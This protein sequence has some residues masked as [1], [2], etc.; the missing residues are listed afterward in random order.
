MAAPIN[1]RDRLLQ[2]AA[3]RL[4][5]VDL[6]SNVNIPGDGTI[7]GQPVVTVVNAA[8][9]GGG[10]SNFFS[11][12]TSDPVGGNPGDAHFNSAT[13]TM[14][15]NI[16][17]VWTA[18]GTLSANQIIT[19]TLAAARIAA[20]SITADKISV[21]TLDV[22]STNMGA[23]TSGTLNGTAI[24]NLI[25]AN[26]TLNAD[27]TLSGGSGAITA[28]D[29][30]N[31][32]GVKPDANATQN[33]FTTS[34]SNPT[35]GAVGDAHWNSSTS[36]MWFNTPA[37][38]SR[39]GTI[40]AGEITVGTLAAA[41][42]AANSIT[43]DKLNVANLAAIN[44]NLGTVNAGS[45]TGTADINITGSA[46]FRGA[47]SSADG[48]ACGVFNDTGTQSFGVI[49]YSLTGN[50]SA[51][52][53]FAQTSGGGNGVYG[54]ALGSTD[55]GVRAQRIGSGTALSVSGP[56]TITSTSQVLN[57][58][59]TR[60][61]TAT[62][63]DNFSG[64]VSFSQITGTVNADQ[65]DGSSKSSFCRQISGNSG[66][67]T[68]PTTSV[69]GVR[70]TGTLFTNGI[71]TRGSGTLML[72][73]DTS[74][75][76]LKTNIV[77]ET[78]GTNF[79]KGLRPVIYEYIDNKGVDVHGFLANEVATLADSKDS[80][81]AWNENG[82]LSLSHTALMAPLVKAFQEVEDRLTTAENTIVS[83]NAE[84]SKLKVA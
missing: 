61:A 45:I 24:P 40:N 58:H 31:I 20:N 5:T 39:G 42:I 37:G 17:N 73:E 35:G 27:G 29:Y 52:A 54:V 26:V 64:N 33:F 21:P 48:S 55:R 77:N 57:L 46:R 3:I 60:A 82:A 72:I 50:G 19:G 75:T 14:W 56:M 81:T 2:T 62:N 49:S 32:S 83:L 69:L 11:T 51:V 16:N 36:V 8:L 53:G 34:T 71:R 41:R 1:D 47:T 10:T 68:T 63:A 66:I 76:V 15:F 44:A 38:W 79:I 13:S 25:N 78:K 12:S 59:A 43:T 70:T 74:D 7:N 30:A 18:G 28:L 4:A 6:P 22:I 80:F 9:A 23:I 84:I 67:T 65:L